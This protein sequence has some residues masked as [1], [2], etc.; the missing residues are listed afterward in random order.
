M[1]RKA[2]TWMLALSAAFFAQHSVA[3]QYFAPGD[4][5]LRHD[6]QLLSDNRLINIP[7]T[8]WPISVADVARAIDEVDPPSNSISSGL[9]QVLSRVRLRISIEQNKGIHK[10]ELSASITSKP[11]QIRGFSEVPRGKNELNATAAWQHSRLSGK[12]AAGYVK[13]DP[14][15]GQQY[16]LDG[17]YLSLSLGNWLLSAGAQQRWWGAAWRSSTMLSNNARPPASIAIQR[18][19]STPFNSKLLS[20]IGP[21]NFTMFLA[22][23]GHDRTPADALLWGMRASFKPHKSIEIALSRTLQMCGSNKECSFASA[24]NAFVG[25]DN[26]DAGSGQDGE[27]DQLA[28]YEFRWSPIVF[29]RP[30]TLYTQVV[31]EDEAGL[32]PSKVFGQFGLETAGYVPEW[33]ASW[34]V[35]AEYANTTADFLKEESTFNVAYNHSVYVSG[36]VYD[37]RVLGHTIDSDSHMYEFGGIL[38]LAKYEFKGSVA[39]GTLNEDANGRNSLANNRS[40]FRLF[41]LSVNRRVSR[42]TLNVIAQLSEFESSVVGKQNEWSLALTLAT[43]LAG[44]R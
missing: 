13:G 41:E 2:L 16:R 3:E 8:T 24:G 22:H 4:A 39:V 29:Q 19:E 32:L 28:S 27:T 6:L 40:D 15:D 25:N 43:D 21:W 10:S 35:Y 1:Y 38:N 30:Y 7:V 17:S 14:F 5:A 31:G 42:V 11:Q 34:R 26:A 36:Y 33:R 44:T 37:G 23:L 9:L 12:L 18:A 20:W